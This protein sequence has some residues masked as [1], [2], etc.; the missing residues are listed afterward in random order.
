M[1]I[2]ADKYVFASEGVIR[3]LGTGIYFGAG[4]HVC[5]FLGG[6]L[7]WELGRR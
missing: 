5:V 6:K 7:G 3:S 1:G 2:H 4:V